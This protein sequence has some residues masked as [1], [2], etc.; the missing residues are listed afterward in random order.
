MKK[1]YFLLFALTAN[2]LA[3]QTT[4]DFTLDGEGLCSDGPLVASSDR[5][6]GQH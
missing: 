2:F 3:A 4:V 1:F 6:G 5:W